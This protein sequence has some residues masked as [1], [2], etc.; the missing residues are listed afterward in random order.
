MN[1]ALL[2]YSFLFDPSETWQQLSQFE[3]DLNAYFNDRGMEARVIQPL[4]AG[5]KIIHITKK[6]EIE[7]PTPPKT[8]KGNTGFAIRAKGKQVLDRG[9]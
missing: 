9:M 6:Q 4:G 8:I 5:N 7:P 3:Q 1:V 2:T